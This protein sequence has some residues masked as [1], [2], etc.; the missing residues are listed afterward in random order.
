MLEPSSS[1]DENDTGTATLPDPD[2]TSSA[3]SGLS[4]SLRGDSGRQ[5]QA[6][7][8]NI[9]CGSPGLNNGPGTPPTLNVTY[10]NQRS[11]SPCIEPSTSPGLAMAASPSQPLVPSSAQNNHFLTD[12]F[13]PAR[14]SLAHIRATSPNP[15][16]LIHEPTNSEL[17]PE[18]EDE[19]AEREEAE[20]K[21]KLQLYVFI[22]RCIAYPFNAKQPSDLNRRQTKI[23]LSQLDQIVNR[24]QSFLNGE[25]Q[26]TADDAF[27]NAI[28][29]YFDAFLKS[30]R[31]HM[32]VAS[33]ACS[34]HDFREVFR[35]NIEKRVRSLPEVEGMTKESMIS[36]W[37][38]KFDTIFRGFDD[39]TKKPG[40][41]PKARPF[42]NILQ[43]SEIIL[44]KEQLY[45]MFQNVLKIKK[46]E[47]QL[48]YN[49]LQVSKASPSE[50]LI[51]VNI[52]TVAGK[53]ATTATTT[54]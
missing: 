47:H 48:L 43:A 20:R 39:E 40:G 13:L 3:I 35:Q 34:A 23:T 21:S 9:S 49:A 29:N 4:T 24:F 14:A 28:H 44:S 8:V 11:V 15:P 36:Q 6:T 18:D 5:S 42:P 25:L 26:I 51:K 22:L 17:E 45:D 41:N 52:D 54:E 16:E 27:T 46:F 10:A 2:D 19:R 12:K 1:E 33:G 31:L 30:N 7:N 53:T 50:M 32:I 37:L 38:T